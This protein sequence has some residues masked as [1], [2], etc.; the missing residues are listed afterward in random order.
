MKTTATKQNTI[1]VEYLDM[2]DRNQPPLSLNAPEG[3]P[4][5]SYDRPRQTIVIKFYQK[6]VNPDLIRRAINETAREYGPENVAAVEVLVSDRVMTHGDGMLLLNLGYDRVIIA[7]EKSGLYR[8]RKPVRLR[9]V[10][11][12][13]Q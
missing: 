10:K 13:E 6:S 11:K 9:K 5:V 3:G 4:T 12:G 2:H 7:N 8:F 1:P